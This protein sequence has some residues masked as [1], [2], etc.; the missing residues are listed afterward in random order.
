[1]ATHASNTVFSLIRFKRLIVLIFVAQAALVGC[2]GPWFKR[3]EKFEPLVVSEKSQPSA[4]RSFASSR[5]R[6]AGPATGNE[7]AASAPRPE[8]QSRKISDATE[9]DKSFNEALEDDS[10]PAEL[11]ELNQRTIA[12]LKNRSSG[13]LLA[14]N[15]TEPATPNKPAESESSFTIS[16]SEDASAPDAQTTETKTK[17]AEAK[18]RVAQKSAPAQTPGT[19]ALATQPKSAKSPLPD[20]KTMQVNYESNGRAEDRSVSTADAKADA[21][22]TA[23]EDRMP[24]NA[25][26]IE[27]P[28]QDWHMLI[29]EARA[30]MQAEAESAASQSPSQ[31]LAIESKIRLMSLALDDLEGAMTPIEFLEPDGEDYFINQMQALHAVTDVSGNPVISRRWTIGLQSQ[32]KAQAHMAAMSNLEIHNVAFCT[33]VDSFGIITKFPQY[34]FQPDQQVL[35]YCELDNFVS[36]K[37]KNEYETKLQGS[38]EIVDSSGRRVTDQLLPPD[39]HICSNQRRDYFI[40]Y[41]IFTPKDIAPGRY[42]LKLTIEDMNGHKFG[43]SSIDFQIVK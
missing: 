17:V 11:R 36:Q 18:D 26:A 13:D 41:R 37:L 3:S 42:T 28:K 4:P 23:N 40:A 32:R 7:L 39:E 24:R 22:L 38:Y 1:M 43:Q 9:D 20:S 8:T 12:A 2:R 19:Q 35:L 14:V 27:T 25:I 5:L 30:L 16:D 10:L 29:Q 31:K 21:N 6:P 33:E 34:H 15:D